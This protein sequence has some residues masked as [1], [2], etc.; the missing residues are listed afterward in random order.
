MGGLTIAKALAAAWR[1]ASIAV[2][3]PLALI[4]AAAL[5]VHFDK[6]SAVRRAVDDAVRET[7]A[8]AELAALAA[9][10][11]AAQAMAAAQGEAARRAQAA[12]M[13]AAQA[14]DALDKALDE[15]ERIN[16][17]MKAEIDDILAAPPPADCTA[18][19][20]LLGRL[21]NN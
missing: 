18:A 15:A 12:A 4:A 7:V 10:R 8:G 14:R 11:D 1:I 17:D 2:P 3:V 6:A 19:D 21:R 16:A 13:A 20:P 5:W 9:E